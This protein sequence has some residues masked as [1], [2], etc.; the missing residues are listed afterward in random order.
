M[1][2]DLSSIV[3]TG[4]KGKWT[5][6]AAIRVA[7]FFGGV[8][9]SAAIS[10]WWA[11]KKAREG[12]DAQL[13][14]VKEFYQNRDLIDYAEQDAKSVANPYE[15]VIFSTSPAQ[16]ESNPPS[17]FDRL[18]YNRAV[19]DAQKTLLDEYGSEA[20]TLSDRGEAQNILRQNPAKITLINQRD[21]MEDHGEQGK[22]I[23]KSSLLYYPEDNVLT[24]QFDDI[25]ENPEF[26]VGKKWVKS[27][28]KIEGQKTVYVRNHSIWVDFEIVEVE[29][30]NFHRDQLGMDGG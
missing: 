1:K 29:D 7:V 23:E 13:V 3:K 9:T 15:T 4:W 28:L 30:G 20:N 19:G 26:V 8:A 6:C 21:Y 17:D 2:I 22:A 24:D 14:E 27:F 18:K 25:I 12:F 10:H 11:Y 16:E 5:K